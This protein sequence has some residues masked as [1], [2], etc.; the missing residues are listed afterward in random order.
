M[1]SFGRDYA[2]LVD[3]FKK[4]QSYM[5]DMLNNAAG[6]FTKMVKQVDR[7]LVNSLSFVKNV[8]AYI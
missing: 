4:N 3:S 7:R 6:D 2:N 8:N 5:S 1:L